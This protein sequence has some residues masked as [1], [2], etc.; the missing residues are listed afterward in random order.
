MLGHHVTNLTDISDDGVTDLINHLNGTNASLVKEWG[1]VTCS[2][3]QKLSEAAEGTGLAFIIF[4]QAIVEL[5][6][7]NYFLIS[8]KLVAKKIIFQLSPKQDQLSG[9]FSSSRCC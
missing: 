2:L 5:P 8:L 4:T 1:L 3:E 9:L 6:G 7:K